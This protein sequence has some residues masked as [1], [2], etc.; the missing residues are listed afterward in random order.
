[1]GYT[2]A[3]HEKFIKTHKQIVSVR[4]D[5]QTVREH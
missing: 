5:K 3:L 2:Y 1:M 4:E